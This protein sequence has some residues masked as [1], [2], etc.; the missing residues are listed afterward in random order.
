MIQREMVFEK[1]LALTLTKGTSLKE[2]IYR[3]MP[4]GLENDFNIPGAGDNFHLPNKEYY[5]PKYLL[6]T[7]QESCCTKF[8]SKGRSLFGAKYLP[9]PKT[10]ST[11]WKMIAAVI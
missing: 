5:N 3:M 2:F 10:K 7:Y 6:G 11:Y 9:W 1:T 8:G 4:F